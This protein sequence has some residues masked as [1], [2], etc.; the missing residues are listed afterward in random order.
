MNGDEALEQIYIALGDV[1][2]TVSPKEDKLI[3]QWMMDNLSIS[4][5]RTISWGSVPKAKIIDTPIYET[6]RVRKAIDQF[7][8]YLP[9]HDDE[10]VYVFWHNNRPALLMPFWACRHVLHLI[11]EVSLEVYM[12][13]IARGWF[14]Q[15]HPFSDEIRGA[16]FVNPTLH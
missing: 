8:Q 7:A 4:F 6:D 11:T 12:L 14:I 10:A 13:S 16:H 1:V 9:I 15:M 5:T 2:S 3:G